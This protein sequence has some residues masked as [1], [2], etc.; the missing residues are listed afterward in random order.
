MS[1]NGIAI[2]WFRKGLRL[3]DNPALVEA[4]RRCKTV[5]P[6]F[7][8]DPYFAKPHIIGVNRYSF[9]LQSL[10]DLHK[11]LQKLGSRLYILQGRPDEQ[12][13]KAID[14]WNVNL[15]SF[16]V[17]TEPYAK[18]RDTQVL[19]LMRS[20]GI[21]VFTSHS[22]TLHPLEDY[23]ARSN[24]SPPHT[25]QA[26]LKLFMSMKANL[27]EESPTPLSIPHD[28]AQDL[29]NVEYNVPTLASMG[30][31]EQ[32]TTCFVGGE[33]EALVRLQA[34]VVSC[35]EYVRTFS[36]PDTSPNSLEPSTTVLSPYLKFGCLSIRKFY[37]VLNDLQQVATQQRLTCTAPPVSLHGQVLTI[38]TM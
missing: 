24:G 12:L 5:Y 23:L 3:H 21:E 31:T 19:Q 2:H 34:K 35:P 33:T 16:E 36:K 6:V 4:C 14:R 18:Q 32:P 9:L 37:T 25:Y 26:F 20:K 1:N 29:T 10:E 38:I 13:L 17:D 27:R 22:H 15:L 8:I 11:S 7:C 30:Y 28:D